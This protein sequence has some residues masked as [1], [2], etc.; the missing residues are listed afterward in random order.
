MCTYG[1]VCTHSGMIAITC[2]VEAPFNNVLYSGPSPVL[3]GS[4]VMYDCQEGYNLSTGDLRRVCQLNSSLNGSNPNCT[5]M[6]L[7]VI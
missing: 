6:S 1:C 4:Q 3:V 7:M 5:G 2:E